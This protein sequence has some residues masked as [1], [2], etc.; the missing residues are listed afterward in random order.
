MILKVA[1]ASPPSVLLSPDRKVIYFWFG[2]TFQEICSLLE[3]I[4]P[5]ISL[6]ET[7]KVISSSSFTTGTIVPSSRVITSPPSISSSKA[8]KYLL[9]PTSKAPISGLPTRKNPRRSVTGAKYPSAS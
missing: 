1:S 8:N 2:N 5:L 9:A 7:L 6:V 3:I 4:S